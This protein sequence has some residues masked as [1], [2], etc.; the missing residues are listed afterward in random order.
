MWEYNSL[1]SEYCSYNSSNKTITIL[2]DFNAYIRYEWLGGSNASLE[3]NGEKVTPVNQKL[4]LIERELKVGD[5][6]KHIRTNSTDN[7]NALIGIVAR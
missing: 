1:D 2:K 5:I 6:I 4:N 3:I 7:Y